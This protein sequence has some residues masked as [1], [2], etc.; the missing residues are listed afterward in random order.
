MLREAWTLLNY[1]RKVVVGRVHETRRKRMGGEP[2]AKR[3]VIC[4]HS[5]LHLKTR[6]WVRAALNLKVKSS[7]SSTLVWSLPFDSM[8]PT[9]V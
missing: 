2:E 6:G 4:P 7:L 3:W 1:P 5:K 9:I 8:C